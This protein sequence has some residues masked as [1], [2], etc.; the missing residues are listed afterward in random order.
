MAEKRCSKCGETKPL[1]EFPPDRR[2]RDGRSSLC[3]A[4]QNEVKRQ[5]RRTG[6]EEAESPYADMSGDRLRDLTEAAWAEAMPRLLERVTV[7]A[8][9]GQLR[10]RVSVQVSPGAPPR[11]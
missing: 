3:R 10:Q 4:C 11:I 8:G 2:A 5:Y 7:A 6:E 9:R 1:A